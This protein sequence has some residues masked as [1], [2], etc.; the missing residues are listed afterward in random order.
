MGYIERVCRKSDLIALLLF[1]CVRKP[2][3]E[4]SSSLLDSL[5]GISVDIT[6][7]RLLTPLQDGFLLD[8]IRI[9]KFLQNDGNLTEQ[10]ILV[11]Q[12]N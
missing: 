1:R 8:D 2:F 12:T 11:V 5:G 4:R 6:L 10:F 9:V 7:G 3:K